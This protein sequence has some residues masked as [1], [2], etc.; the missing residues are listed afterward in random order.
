[1]E[2]VYPGVWKVTLGQPEALT[3]VGLRHRDP[4]PGGDAAPCPLPAEVITGK[5]TARGYVVTLPLEADEQ[6][7]GLG[8]QLLSFNQRGLKKTLR[9]NS[10]PRADL[11]DSHAPVPFFA[12]TRGYA[13]LVDTARYATFYFGQAVPRAAAAT[14]GPADLAQQ[15]TGSAETMYASHAVT[16]E[17][18]VYIEVP[19]AAGVEIYIFAGPAMRDAVARYNRFSGGGC[20]PPRWGLGVWYRPR[21]DYDEAQTVALADAFHADGIPCDV[22]GLEPGWQT[23]TYS[24]TYV[25]SDKFPDPKRLID[26][27][28]ARGKHLN[29]WQHVFVHP[30]S[31]LYG[32]MTPYAGDFTVWGGLVPD[33]TIPEARRTFA[34]FQDAAHVAL[35]VSGYKL[36]ECDGSDFITP[37]WSFPEIE[38]FPSGLD[39]EQYHS[40]LGHHYQETVYSMFRARNRRTY[41]EVRNAHALAA[42]LPFVLYSDLYAH[43]DF[44]RGVVNMGFSGLLW[45]PEVRHADSEEDLLRRLQAVIYSPQALVN[46]WYIKNPPWKQW[47]T[48]ENNNDAFLPEADALTAA[49]RGLFKR[50]MA[51]VPYLYAAFARYAQ[52]GTPPFRALVMDYPDD[53]ET[54]RIDDAWLIGDR[55]LVAPVTAGKTTRDLYLP[56]GTWQDFDTG[57]VFAGG[58]THTLNVPVDKVPVFVKA[59]SLLPL[60]QPTLHAGD[61]NAL[62]LTVRVYGDGSLPCTLFEDDSDT[63]A[64]ETGAFNTTEIA[65]D[66][67]RVTLTRTGSTECPGYTIAGWERL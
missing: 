12:S 22:V 15:I 1:M 51:L 30:D 26:E 25:W 66:G 45:C 62:R 34:A 64:Y 56:A 6:F 5:A 18:H 36:D 29:L 48:E 60:A 24:C 52:D 11:G 61:P 49:V 7:Y 9:V 65:W 38:Q 8:L 58:Q 33:L 54:H 32:P 44:I 40:L 21:L 19:A 14:A 42:P 35:G 50:R 4:L 17:G 37:Q 16:A 46:A 28:R 23:H 59:G 67:T 10:D 43:A 2:Q 31:P 39:G 53:P 47:R 13:V 3:P 20:L 63:F 55:M 41:N 57:A 27:M